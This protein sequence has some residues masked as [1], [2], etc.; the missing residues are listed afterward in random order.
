MRF[1]TNKSV[2]YLVALLKKYNIRNIVVSPGTT[3]LE[4]TAC[5]QEDGGF[6]LYS[7]VDERSA[8][9]MACGLAEESKEP[10]VI[11]CTE[12]TASRNYFAGITEAY[13][14]KLPIL[15]VTGVHRYYYIGQNEPQVIDRSLSPKDT[16]KTKYHLPIINN[17]EDEWFTILQINRA[18]N[19]LTHHGP[20]PVHIDLPCCNENYDFS[21]KALPEVKKI[22]YLQ[23]GDKM[24]K[25][26]RG[27]IAI[28]IGSHI[29]FTE[30]ETNTIDEFCQ[31]YNAVVFSDHSSGFYGRFGF[32]A[33]ILS[34]Q[35]VSNIYKDLKLIIHI[36]EEVADGMT[37][38]RLRNTAKVWRISEDGIIKDT[39]RKIDKFFNMNPIYFFK[40]YVENTALP[41]KKGCNNNEFLTF[42]KKE[43]E[44][45]FS[46]IRDI[47]FS[48]IYIA[49]KI[50]PNLPSNCVVNLG[51]SNTIRAW[52][53]FD[54]PE[55]VRTYANV[56][57]RGID[58]TLSTALGGALANPEKIHFCVLGDLSFF[59]DL[60]SLGNRDFPNTLRVLLIN[61]NGGGVFKLNGAPGHKYFGDEFTGKY[62]A[63]NNHFGNSSRELV[64]HF[65]T[66]LGMNYLSADNKEEFDRNYE[67]FVNPSISNE[68]ILFEVFLEEH[69]DRVGFDYINNISTIGGA[70]ARD[71]A[72]SVLGE[73]GIKAVKKII[74]R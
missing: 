25:I 38:N 44:K 49:S 1:T 11:T 7:S 35:A 17:E 55:G 9:Y 36:G 40:Y 28:L 22:D 24:P 34:N 47:P 6:I 63:A 50:I 21:V 57:C 72:K 62:I 60:N 52:S 59:Y 73:K 3:N 2:L 19:D 56:G 33:S 27:R 71:L 18:L 39:F 54:F 37:Q 4:F 69:A 64:K 43:K 12:A 65:S 51:M 53:L 68:A 58:G 74:N 29:D 46:K 32:H 67:T 10:I 61:N 15:A 70:G 30:T 31:R 8:A 66:D 14:R 20:G 42:C 13:H 41:Q 23:L 26:E 5:L 48:N 16:F 45:L